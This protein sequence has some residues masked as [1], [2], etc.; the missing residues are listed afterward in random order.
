MGAVSRRRLL[1]EIAEVP[2]FD[3]GRLTIHPQ[4][5]LAYGDGRPLDLSVR[6]LVLLVELRRYFGRTRTRGELVEAVWGEGEQVSSRAVDTLVARLREKLEKAVP[7]VAYIHT[8]HGI[9]YGFD[10]QSDAEWDD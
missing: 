5:F 7:G 10:P 2:D 6:E 9:G 1:Q 4:R 8:N 3:D